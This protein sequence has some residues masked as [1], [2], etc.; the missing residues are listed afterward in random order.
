MIKDLHFGFRQPQ[1][2]C[3]AVKNKMLGSGLRA[4]LD[5]AMR[6]AKTL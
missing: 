5:P 4:A 3:P 2:V 6:S 1:M